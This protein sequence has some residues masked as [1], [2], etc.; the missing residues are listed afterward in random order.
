M[1]TDTKTL[2]EQLLAAAKTASS[3]IPGLQGV[4]AAITIGEKLVDVV[5]DLTH[6]TRDD[7]TQADIQA[8]RRTLAAAVKAKA[9]RTA[10]RFD[11]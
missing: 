5:G 3:V 2:I 8:T 4:G 9:E 7:R 1:A 11:G 10:D 6:L